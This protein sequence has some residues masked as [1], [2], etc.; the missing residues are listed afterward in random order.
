M[1]KHWRHVASTPRNG[2]T[3]DGQYNSELLNHTSMW[4]LDAVRS[5]THVE[6]PA[7]SNIYCANRPYNRITSYSFVRN[8]F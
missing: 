6:V 8:A 3:D 1:H 7:I 2:G 5:I 4:Y